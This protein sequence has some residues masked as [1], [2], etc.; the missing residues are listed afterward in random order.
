MAWTVFKIIVCGA[1]L[2]DVSFDETQT[3]K[4]C[5]HIAV[6]ATVADAKILIANRVTGVGRDITTAFAV[7]Y[8]APNLLPGVS[9]ITPRPRIFYVTAKGPYTDLFGRL[10]HPCV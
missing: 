2:I 10:N 1:A 6:D 3:N 5:N 4:K 8:G 7:L 9:D